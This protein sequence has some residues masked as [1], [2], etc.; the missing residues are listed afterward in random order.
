MTPEE[1][2][3]F[4]INA[5]YHTEHCPK[6][7]GARPYNGG[8]W[9]YSDGTTDVW[10]DCVVCGRVLLMDHSVVVPFVGKEEQ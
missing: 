9:T 6:C 5:L 4:T 2:S 1:V 7:G 3:R 8:S 10:V